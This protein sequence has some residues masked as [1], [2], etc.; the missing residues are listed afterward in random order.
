VSSHPTYLLTWCLTRRWP[1]VG[2]SRFLKSV[3]SRHRNGPLLVKVFIKPDPALS[4]RTYHSRLNGT[5]QPPLIYSSLSDLSSG[6]RD[7]LSDIPNVYSYQ[8]FSESEKAG[9]I[10]RQWLASSLYDRIRCVPQPLGG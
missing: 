1:S 6:E 2:H 8:V 3:K 7:N 4:L 5:L 10:I 9:Y